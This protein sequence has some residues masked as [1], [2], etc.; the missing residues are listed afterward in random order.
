MEKHFIENKHFFSVTK[1]HK[2]MEMIQQIRRKK[3]YDLRLRLHGAIY[4]PDSFVLM[5]RQRV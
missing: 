2:S 4:R 1:D 5:L 3:L